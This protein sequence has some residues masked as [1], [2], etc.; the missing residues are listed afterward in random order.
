[1]PYPCAHPAAALLLLG[2]LGRYGAP[3]ALA[4]GCVIPDAWYFVPGL[5]RDDSHGLSGLLG[6]CLPAGL[7]AY[8]AFHLLLKQPLL[9]LLPERLSS[10]LSAFAAPAFPAAR[11]HAVIAC[12]LLGACTHLAW[13]AVAHASRLLQH[14][15]TLL[16][17]AYV[18]G[19]IWRRVRSAPS[20]ALPPAFALSPRAR[21]ATPAVLI[22]LSIGWAG[23]V[24]AAQALDLP[25]DMADLRHALRTAG[26]AGAQA[27]ALSTIGY[28]MLWKL[29]R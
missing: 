12:L 26:L 1:M 22:L 14:A 27:L 5:T 7:L 16:G 28:A 3:S 24:A 9:A 4:I 15:S 29:L 25:G 11:W 17:T 10:R 8:L 20:Q 2:P 23:R 13:D 21:H 18:A 19:W 6:F